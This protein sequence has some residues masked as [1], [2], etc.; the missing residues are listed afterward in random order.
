VH[1]LPEYR[2][3]TLVQV[4]KTS[5]AIPVFKFLSI[6]SVS[7]TDLFEET[8]LESVKALYFFNQARCNA[9]HPHSQAT[10]AHA[11]FDSDDLPVAGAAYIS[12]HNDL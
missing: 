11:S 12:R 7:S 8:I 1:I 10:I 9:V 6:T 3:A 5:S 2:S 4:F